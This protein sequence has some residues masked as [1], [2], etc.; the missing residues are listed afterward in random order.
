VGASD[1]ELFLRTPQLR[2]SPEGEGRLKDQSRSSSLMPVFDR[3][4]A[5]TRLTIT[6][7]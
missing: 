4:F 2:P 5:S 1:S 3:V 6:A 7:Q